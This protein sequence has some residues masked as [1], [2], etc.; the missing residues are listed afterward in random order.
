MTIDHIGYAVKRIDRA[1]AAFED[2]GFSFD[3]IVDDHDRNIRI[4]FGEKDGYRIELV[5]PIDKTQKSP[6][7]KYLH[8]IGPTPY[9]ICYRSTD[10]EGDMAYLQKNGYKVIIEPAK[11]IA[12]DNRKVVFLMNLGLGLIE[13][14]ESE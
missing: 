13:I 4:S 11:A 7:D 12:F 1:K 8:D 5:C 3:P 14:V 2:L 10:M 6:V 9:H